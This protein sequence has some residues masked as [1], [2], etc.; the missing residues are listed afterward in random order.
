MWVVRN[1]TPYAVDRTWVQDKDAN[2]L[3]LVAV[4]A[5]FD[6]LQDGST[7]LAEEQEPPLKLG[8]HVGEPGQS[9]LL[10]EAD[11]FGVKANTDV[12]VNA[13]AYAPAGRR[14]TSVDVEFSVGPIKKRLRV[15]GERVWEKSAMGRPAMSSPERFD[16]MPIR[17]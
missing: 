13:K 9:S 2:K 10:Y 4:K 14:V 5:T 6:I 17:Y 16:S 1:Q 11:L 12:L 7:R 15:S 8:T 3:W